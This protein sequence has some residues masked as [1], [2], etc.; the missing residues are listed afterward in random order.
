MPEIIINDENAV[1]FKL[2]PVRKRKTH[3]SFSK[4][5]DIIE[6]LA[7]KN[8]KLKPNATS[9]FT[10]DTEYKKIHHKYSM[11]SDLLQMALENSKE[12]VTDFSKNENL[13]INHPRVECSLKMTLINALREG[14][15]KYKQLAT[16]IELECSQ[17]VDAFINYYQD[18]LEEKAI[19]VWFE[20]AANSKIAEFLSG[21]ELI[22][23][24]LEKEMNQPRE[25]IWSNILKN[26]LTFAKYAVSQGMKTNVKES[27]LGRRIAANYG[28]H[29][30]NTWK[31]Y[32]PLKDF[33]DCLKTQGYLLGG[34]ALGREYHTECPSFKKVG[35]MEVLSWP[36]GSFSKEKGDPS[37]NLVIIIGAS[38][39]GYQN[40]PQDLVYFI[41]PLENTEG[42]YPIYIVSYKGFTERLNTTHG[43]NNIALFDFLDVDI[44]K[45]CYF[46]YHPMY[47]PQSV[48]NRIQPILPAQ[49][50]PVSYTPQE[51]SQA[52][53]S[54][55]PPEPV[56]SI[57]GAHDKW[58][59]FNPKYIKSPSTKENSSPVTFFQNSKKEAIIQQPPVQT[60][61]QSPETDDREGGEC[62]QKYIINHSID[63]TEEA[64]QPIEASGLL[65]TIR[66]ALEEIGN[67]KKDQITYPYALRM[68]FIRMFQ[69]LALHGKIENKHFTFDDCTAFTLTNILTHSYFKVTTEMLQE[70]LLF[71][72][73]HIRKPLE[74]YFKKGKKLSHNNILLS[75]LGLYQ[76]LSSS[77]SAQ[78]R[79]VQELLAGIKIAF[80]NIE[81]FAALN[82][83]PDS[84]YAM[85]VNLV[86][87]VECFNSLGK[88][89]KS[90]SFSIKNYLPDAVQEFLIECRLLVRNPE[91]HVFNSKKENIAVP[92]RVTIVTADN[93]NQI[94]MPVPSLI[95]MLPK[96]EEDTIDTRLAF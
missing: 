52:G 58:R 54:V 18:D 64:E 10:I 7:P 74:D 87:A 23:D 53:P 26:P 89:E 44:N 62:Y 94:L 41:N 30:E 15:K 38:K 88:L 9:I 8:T 45:L 86:D 56:I 43:Y 12:D 67:L 69:A 50:S 60:V 57:V 66:D 77:L 40:T 31:P 13:N 25:Q 11:C 4:F 19:L 5:L 21:Y 49:L 34:G 16:L 70:T 33:M 91:R 32:R 36:K 61:S 65:K 6:L 51:P 1:I 78:P 93:L 46:F 2:P 37:G 22:E 24:I 3:P 14:K 84:H 27:L 76:I 72:N 48:Q 28:F 59:S 39:N 85:G 63:E 75:K 17:Y 29:I 47:A 81:A 90:L 83:Q 96:V 68:I 95:K 92:E 79:T 35:E 20:L 82:L 55:R 42:A 73:K 80:V 71:V